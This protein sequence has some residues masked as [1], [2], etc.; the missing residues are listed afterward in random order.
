[1]NVRHIRF[2]YTSLNTNDKVRRYS[3]KLGGNIVEAARDPF[4]RVPASRVN[5]ILKAK[6][7]TKYVRRIARHIVN[8]L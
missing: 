4:P 5:H 6:R 3:N 2:R 1:M 7:V 8:D